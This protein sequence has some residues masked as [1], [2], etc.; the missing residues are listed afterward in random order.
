MC[1]GQE[2]EM[3]VKDV[4]EKVEELQV[5]KGFLFCLLVLLFKL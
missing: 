3:L 1:Q 5:S 4:N 2:Y